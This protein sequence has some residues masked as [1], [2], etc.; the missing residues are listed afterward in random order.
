MD[1]NLLPAVLLLLSLGCVHHAPTAQGTAPASPPPDPPAQGQGEDE[2][3]RLLAAI[4]PYVQ[5]ARATYPWV[6]DRFLAGL[7]EGAALFVTVQLHDLSGNMEQAF[8]QVESIRDGRIGGNIL[9]DINTVVDYHKGEHYSF[10]ES[11]LI[12]WTLANADGSEEGNVVGTFL[13]S[14]QQTAH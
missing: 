10:P 8:V 1:R 4:E 11:E 13:D 3:Q 5:K 12:D 6:R 9:N 2:I 14:W 7:P